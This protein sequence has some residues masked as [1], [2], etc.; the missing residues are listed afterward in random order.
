MK[1]LSD[2]SEYGLRAVV[3]MAQRPGEPQKARDI[4]EGTHSSPGY[5]VKVLQLLARQGI[6]SAQRGSHG[7]FSL[8][9]DPAELT[10]LE[11][12]SA[13]DPIERIR[14]CPLG[15]DAHGAE[16]CPLHRRIDNAIATIE[17]AFAATTIE[18]LITERSKSRPLCNH[19][20]VG[21]TEADA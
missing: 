1:L 14:T 8:Q 2:A 13:V 21:A 12:I 16:L 18:E 3:W 19:L 17:K 15:L 11:V 9:R 5:L 20:T 6:V 10:V 4:A 7:G